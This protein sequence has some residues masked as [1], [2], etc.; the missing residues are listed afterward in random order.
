MPVLRIPTLE[1]MTV[2]VG[3]QLSAFN[4]PVILRAAG[5][6]QR[7]II[8]VCIAFSR[9]LNQVLDRVTVNTINVYNINVL[10]E[11]QILS[12]I[13]AGMLYV[14]DCTVV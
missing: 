9:N 8:F 4:K 5:N 6:Y 3:L 10:C 7:I 12:E 11:H 2:L 14:Y 13:H 1:H